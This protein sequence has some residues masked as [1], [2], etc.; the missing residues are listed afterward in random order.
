MKIM[1]I[2]DI[3]L[4]TYIWGKVERISPEAPVPVVSCNRKEQRLGG[5]GNVAVNLLSLGAV[6]LLCSITGDDE[7]GKT[8][9]EIFLRLK[10]DTKGLIADN[11]RPTTIKTRIISN[12]QQLLRVD[13][14]SDKPI[15]EKM[16]S[17]FINH[18]N[19]MID[20]DNFNAI[21]FQDYDK[22]LLTEKIISHIVRIARMRNIPTLVDPKRR[23]FYN[24]RGVSLFKPNFKE[25]CEGL[26][27]N[28][29]KENVEMIFSSSSE[30]QKKQDIALMLITLSDKG[31]FISDSEQYF[32]LPAHEVN[33]SDVSGAGDTVISV[34]ALCLAAGLKPRQIAALSNLAGSM[35]CEKPGVVPVD[36]K[37]LMEVSQKLDW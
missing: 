13:E 7:M 32:S 11:S 22:G 19:R 30:F 24:Y 20:S 15:H 12:S 31:I 18:F 23:N 9:K 4:D 3:M 17:E 1:V 10:L 25:L 29:Q 27:S 26:Q 16:E 28:I 6:P 35:V 34:A 5:A 36:A 33:I 21:I 8:V 37:I 2:G 14:E